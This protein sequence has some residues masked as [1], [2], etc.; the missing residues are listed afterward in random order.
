[1]ADSK[2]SWNSN[3]LNKQ[4]QP[5]NSNRHP[6]NLRGKAIGLW[7]AQRQRPANSGQTSSHSRPPPSQPIATIELSPNEIQRVTEVRQLFKHQQYSR[8]NFKESSSNIDDDKDDN[9]TIDDAEHVIQFE[10]LHSSFQYFD[11]LD[12]KPEVDQTLFDDLRKKQCSSLYLNLDIKRSCLPI[13]AYR[14]QILNTIE[15]NQIFVLVGETGSG[16]FLSMKIESNLQF[17]SSRKNHPNC[18]IYSR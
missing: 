9:P 8:K 18:S 12:R 15:Q 10:K 1:M 4:C 6:S 3:N 14:Q 17:F 13:T 5:S 16:R 2:S 11:P 7:Y